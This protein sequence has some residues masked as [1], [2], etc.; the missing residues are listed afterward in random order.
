MLKLI[1]SD[2]NRSGND[3]E[4][5]LDQIARQG[6]QELLKKALAEEVNTYLQDHET[7]KDEGGKHLV[8][9]NG[10]GKQRTILTG[11]GELKVEAPRINDRRV[12]KKFTSKILPPYLRK[13]PNVESVL[14]ILY[15]KGLSANTFSEALEELFGGQ[16]KGLSKST[17]HALKSSWEKDLDTWRASQIEERFV[18]LWA[19]GVHVKVRLGED[20]KLCLLVVMGVTESG[21]K[22]L[23]AVHAGYRES[24]TSWNEVFSDLERRGLRAPLA[25]VGDGALGLWACT[26]E[27]KL[28]KKTKE[29]RCWVHKMGNVLDKLPKRTQPRAKS[30]LQDMMNAETENDA[31]KSR[32]VFEAEL[33]EKFPKAVDCLTKDWKALTGHFSFPAKHWLHIRTTNPIESMFATVKLRTK[34][35]KGAGS[36]KMAETMAFKLMKEAEKKWRRIRGHDEIKKVLEG[37][38]YKD[39]KLVEAKIDQQEIA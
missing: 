38:V 12:G 27:M 36:L 18:Y 19:D 33:H 23:L 30:L 21:E 17:I 5:T 34:V 1:L 9:K 31:Y 6:A 11:S 13:S 22:K 32:K 2:S 3:Q 16:V 10:K 24:K 20:K 39:G 8:V 29:L 15:L 28:F 14:P 26:G 7:S 4:L 25:I 35:T 37:A